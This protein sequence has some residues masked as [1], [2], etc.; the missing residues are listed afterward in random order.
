MPYFLFYPSRVVVIAPTADEISRPR[1]DL[2]QTAVQRAA[3]P[4]HSGKTQTDL[5]AKDWST[6]PDT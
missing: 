2:L 3:E 6:M 5:R 4:K 1:E